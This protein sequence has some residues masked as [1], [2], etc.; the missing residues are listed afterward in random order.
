MSSDQKTREEIINDILRRNP[1]LQKILMQHPELRE[2]IFCSGAPSSSHMD[3]GGE[4][5]FRSSSPSSAASS[6]IEQKGYRSGSPSFSAMDNGG[7]SA[8]P[9]I[10]GVGRSSSG[11]FIATAAY[12]CPLSQEV[13]ILKE[14]RDKY[15][16]LNKY[17]RAFVSLYYRCSPRVAYYIY[18]YAFLKK[19]V[20][21]GLYPVVKICKWVL[22]NE[23]VEPNNPLS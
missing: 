7:R 14:I 17:G 8:F 21:K 3:N 23:G 2:K 12:G 11:C 22:K 4:N 6:S 1:N 20:R 19:I 15:L 18:E 13:E 10:Q 16:L 5:V 9:S